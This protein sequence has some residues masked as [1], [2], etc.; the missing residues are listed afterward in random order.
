MSAHDLREERCRNGVVTAGE[1]GRGS[2][3]VPVQNTSTRRS[4]LE[5]LIGSFYWTL[6][7]PVF[8][9]RQEP[10]PLVWP[11]TLQ[12]RVHP[13]RPSSVPGRRPSSRS[14]AVVSV[15]G[16]VGVVRTV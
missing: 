13:K 16:T 14:W 5:G 7:V 8:A 11:T 3:R 4:V 9:P 6:I 12:R 10:K 2:S 15:V 1:T